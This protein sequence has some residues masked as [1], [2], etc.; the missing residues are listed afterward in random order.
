MGAGTRRLCWANWL[1]ANDFVWLQ[2]EPFHA[3]NL[4]TSQCMQRKIKGEGAHVVIS[5]AA[6]DE[7]LAGYAG[8]Y[9]GPYLRH[10]LGKANALSFA[11]ELFANTEIKPIHAIK[12]L[13]A[14]VLWS[15]EQRTRAGMR[16]SGELNLLHKILAPTVIAAELNNPSTKEEYSFHGRSVANMT[17]RLMNYWL[18]SGAKSI[19]GIPLESRAP[20]LDYRVV[21]FCTQLPPEYLIHNGWHKHVLRKAVE[22]YVPSGVIWRRNKMGFPFPYREWLVASKKIA[23]KRLLPIIH[24]NL[25]F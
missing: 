22:E 6:G 9:Q 25:N 8:D 5:G 4:Y 16:R 3:P 19:Y 17:H 18:R 21:E 23:E 24:S 13:V 2:E 1:G 12:G 20:F 7:M 11:S 14:D 15:Q 10:L